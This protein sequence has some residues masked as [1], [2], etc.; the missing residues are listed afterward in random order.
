MLLKS[1]F[2]SILSALSL[3]ISAENILPPVRQGV[4]RLTCTSE[5]NKNETCYLKLDCNGDSE[6][7]TLCIDNI[8]CNSYDECYQR[9]SYL[10]CDF[11]QNKCKLRK[12]N[13]RL[14]NNDY[15]CESNFCTWFIWCT[16]KVYL[17]MIPMPKA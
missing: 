3:F 7:T 14:C 15:E 9:Y 16:T 1:I 11:K 12:P 17:K 6:N 2:I 10:Y 13:R 5:Y 8:Y 4:S